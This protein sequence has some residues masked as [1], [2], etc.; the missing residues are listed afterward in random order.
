MITLSI[1]AKCIIS[2]RFLSKIESNNKDKI[3][4]CVT[5]ESVP[6]KIEPEKKIDM[7][8]KMIFSGFESNRKN[9]NN[10]CWQTSY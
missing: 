7:W 6:E 5:R 4:S 2:K 3:R 1:N 9:T 8:S 10:V